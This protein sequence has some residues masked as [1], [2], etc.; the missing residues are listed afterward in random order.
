MKP[1]TAKKIASDRDVSLGQDPTSALESTELTRRDFLTTFESFK[2]DIIKSMRAESDEMKRSMVFMSNQYDELIKKMDAVMG[3]NAVLEGNV[4]N[5][6][7]ENCVLKKGLNYLE[8]RVNFLE[9][10]SLCA[11]LEIRGLPETP[12]EN[13]LETWKKINGAVYTEEISLTSIRRAEMKVPS[14]NPRPIIATLRD[15]SQRGPFLTSMRADLKSK[16][17]RCLSTSVLNLPSCPPSDLYVS[18]HL[19][20]KTRF[21]LSRAKASAKAGNYKYVWTRGGRVLMRKEDGS[22]V[23]TIDSEQDLKVKL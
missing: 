12:H 20:G 13:L 3:I 8:A 21:L 7:T 9:H 15:S 6:Q 19:T 23:I 18:E 14:H 17:K 4:S 16:G 2:A 10:Q 5:L 22:R 1:R 11:D